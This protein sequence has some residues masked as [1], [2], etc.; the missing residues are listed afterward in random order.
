MRSAKRV[1]L[2]GWDAADWKIINPLLDAGLMP[3]LNAFV[4]SGVMGNIATLQPILSPMLWNSIATG[5]RPY[6]HG[7]YG[8]VELK[9]DGT[10]IRPVMSTSRTSK[11]I[12]NILSQ[13]GLKSQVF[14]WFASHPAE[15]INGITV[16][17][18]Y[19]QSPR[20][21][22]GDWSMP[23]NCVHPRRLEETFKELRVH[24]TEIEG[25]HLLPFIPRAAEID[26]QQKEGRWVLNRLARI[27][28]ECATVHAAATWSMENEPWDLCAIYYSTIDRI[29][30]DFML[31]HPPRYQQIDDRWFELLRDVVNGIYRFHDTMLNRLVQ[32]AGPDTLVII[33]SDHG[34][35]SDH[36]RPRMAR[37]AATGP[38]V[39][40]RPHGML[41]MRG[42][43]VKPDERLYGAS[44]L[45]VAPTILTVL[46]LPVGQDMDGRVLVDAFVE[47]PAISSIKTWEEVSGDAG[48][49]PPE[50]AAPDPAAAEQA[51]QQLV[52]L[53]YVQPLS[54]EEKKNIA[55]VR[56]ECRFNLA[57]SLTDGSLFSEA[58][59]I[60]QELHREEPDNR[61]TL[62]LAKTHIHLR[63]FAEARRLLEPM[64]AQTESN[65]SGGT[66]TAGN[67]N[68]YTLVSNIHLLMGVVE[69]EDGKIDK[70]LSHLRRAEEADATTPTLYIQLGNLYLKRRRWTEAERAF[71]KALSIDGDNSRACHGLSVSLLRQNRP[72]EAVELSLRAVGLQ[73]FFPAAHFQLGLILARL[74]WIERA[75]QAFETGLTM[76][77]GALV[78]H[79]YLARLYT[80]LGL[81]AKA[82]IHRAAGTRRV[83]ATA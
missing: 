67:G 7:I 10:G 20:D 77:P 3:A 32:L 16:S 81:D 19:N 53:G 59:P 46:G 39:W 2:I 75:A 1:L 66:D 24:P 8:F 76:W 48:L 6:K 5:K 60:F 15:P 37:G 82:K 62:Q 73:H 17:N 22:T 78:A 40:H 11:T 63:Q 25:C 21:M 13:N 55:L 83:S 61:S 65:N 74:R 43:G 71:E 36:L 44:I 33:M 12:W 45:D 58:L 56:R 52:E 69:F 26:Q 80:R 29:C 18:F 41:A 47:A 70:A 14:G 30:H 38:V 28:S 9:P 79:R 27:L 50:T 31:Y 35:H 23:A 34:F 68:A 64:V 49:H 57:L 4:D 54:D 42:P 51:L 72:V